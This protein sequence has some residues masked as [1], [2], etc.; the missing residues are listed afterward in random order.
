MST[1]NVKEAAMK[2]AEENGGKLAV[3]SK[4]TIDSKED[5]SIAYTPGVAAV[6]SAIA[7]NEELAYTLTTKKNTVA[8]ISDGS[9]VLGLGNIGAKAAMPV[10]EGKAALFQRFAGI[11]SI[12]IVLD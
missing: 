7:E 3:V 12:P 5:L 4:V 11:D 10:M 6:S 8:V 1:M 2:Q 9:A